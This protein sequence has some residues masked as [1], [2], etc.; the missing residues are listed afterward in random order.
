[1][2]I[3][4][5]RTL[6]IQTAS[7]LFY[8]NG[9]NST[10]INEVI[11]KAGI[12]K[13]TLYSHFK[14]KEDLC[15]AYLAYRDEILSKNIREFCAKQAKG[16]AQ[17]LAILKFLI[18]FFK[19]EQFNGCWCIRTIAEIQPDNKNIRQCI[20]TSKLNFLEF[21]QSLVKENKPKL[22]LKAQK[23]LAR[24]IYLLYESAVSESHLHNNIWPIK[25]SINLL[26]DIIKISNK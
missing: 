16:D 14:S 3:S 9:Y 18:P 2:A 17:L 4:K 24:Q 21:I 12:A 25:E 5:T 7:E 6:I 8:K 1:M 15:I 22:V 13:A 11:A 19:S 20:Q 10:G 26:K 23:Q